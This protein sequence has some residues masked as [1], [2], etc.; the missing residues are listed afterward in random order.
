MNDSLRQRRLYYDDAYTVTF[1]AEVVAAAEAGGRAAVVLDRTYFY[2]ESGG[3]LA[4][5]GTLGGLPVVD[6]QA[7]ASE[8]VLHVLDAATGAAPAGRLEGRIDPARRFDFMQQHTGQ[9]VL[10]AAFE[11]VAGAATLSS[12]LGEAAGTIEV[13]LDAVDWRAVE[14]IEAAANRV[15]WED[16][17]VERH[18]V[19]AEGLKRFTLRKPP[20]VEREIRIVEI[21]GWDVSACGGTHV[22]RTGEVGAIKVLGWERVRG[23]VRFEFVCGERALRDHAWRT[24]AMVEA[25]RR[26]TVADRDLLDHLERALAER[27]RLRRDLAEAREALIIREARERAGDPPRGVAEIF[28]SRPRGEL[29]TFAIKCLEAGAPWVVAAAAAPDPALVLGRAKGS[30]SDL[31]QLLPGLL[32]RS[33]G[34]GG[35]SPDLIQVTADGAG[36]AAEAFRWAEREI[37]AFSRGA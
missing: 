12:R 30:E 33:R 14:R 29:R 13:A 16:R 28:P 27:D 3:Q 31:R 20:K 21:P 9:H 37:R 36:P 23:N 32:E 1:E 6:V 8:R 5:R 24:E 35:G 7:D 34:K 26:R 2:P 15:V 25:A 19:D 10:S 22:R 17:P 4:D 18:W 11:R